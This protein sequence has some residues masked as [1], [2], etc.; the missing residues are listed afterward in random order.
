M[1]SQNGQAAGDR[2]QAEHGF[3]INLKSEIEIVAL[4]AKLDGLRADAREASANVA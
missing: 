1:M 4:H 2:Q 3:E